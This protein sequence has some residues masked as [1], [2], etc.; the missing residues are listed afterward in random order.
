MDLRKILG[1][2]PK[3][4]SIADIE[5]ALAAARAAGE[6]A[7]KAEG[8]LLA[9]RGGVL[10]NGTPD[11]I[12]RAEEALARARLD[13]DHAA[14]MVPILEAKLADAMRGRQ[15]AE[16][17]EAFNLARQKAEVARH[18]LAETYPALA[19]RMASEVLRPEADALAAILAARAALDL[20]L[21]AGVVSLPN[22]EDW[23]LPA[24]PAASLADQPPGGGMVLSLGE[25]IALPAIASGAAPLWTG[26]HG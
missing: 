2:R 10:L 12:T 16:L 4:E 14:T 26:A 18:A 24:A 23:A 8:E 20:A 15:L 9:Q 3:T 25:R 6:A 11:E 7:A 5:A 1:M 17:R 19:A 22:G 13:A 21:R